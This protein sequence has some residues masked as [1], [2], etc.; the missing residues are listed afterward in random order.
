MK[1]DFF[2][3]DLVKPVD[4]GSAVEC[5][6]L[7]VRDANG[8]LIALLSE[9]R[10]EVWKPLKIGNEAGEALAT[11]G[12]D[13]SFFKGSLLVGGYLTARKPLS[14]TEGV[15]VSDASGNSTGSLGPD[16]LHFLDPTNHLPTFTIHSGRVDVGGSGGAGE[17][18]LF[19]GKQ[20]NP[21]LHLD[22]T[23]IEIRRE[24][25]TAAISLD[26]EEGIRSTAGYIN[27][28]RSQ[29][30]VGGKG[31]AG[32]VEIRDGDEKARVLL[33]PFGLQMGCSP[34]GS[35]AQPPFITLKDHNQ[36]V[37]VLRADTRSL[38]L[39]GS[40]GPGRIRILAHDNSSATISV[41]ADG[42]DRAILEIGT[43]TSAGRLQLNNPRG[44]PAVF[45]DGES[46]SVKLYNSAGQQTLNLDG[47]SGDISLLNGDC[48]EEFE[49]AD[50]LSDCAV[51]PGTVLVI[52]H[53]Q[54]LSP[55]G[56]AYDKKVAGVVSAG[57]GKGPAIVLG[58][59][60]SSTKRAA[61]ALIGRVY[62]KVDAG[63]GPIQVGDLLT[64]SPTPGHAMKAEDP[65]R[66]FG[67]VLGKALAALESGRS[68]VPVL[69]AMQ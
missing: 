33:D 8:Q 39:G 59:G 51:E 56:A 13:D 37:C 41:L 3:P 4:G 23:S 16:G 65:L 22:P 26:L 30:Y 28:A 29:L 61:I 31:S 66:A 43:S 53:D 49:I 36:D 62:C 27:M 52:E 64:T 5:T 63:Y 54:R 18:L 21:R 46:C 42:P 6:S 7:V 68:L 25:G 32:H 34:D 69:V 11:L 35:E 24:D 45:M 19:D 67:A 55:C 15:L 48:A 14:V 9:D 50:D 58:R 20:N 44:G 60:T 38:D 10:M 57:N 17:I 47:E 12:G 2:D 40:G 1:E